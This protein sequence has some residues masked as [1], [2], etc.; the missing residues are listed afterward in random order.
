[1]AQSKRPVIVTAV[2]V[3]YKGQNTESKPGEMSISIT[4][5][6]G[7]PEFGASVVPLPARIRQHA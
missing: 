1:M 6:N 7:A 2:T 4:G 3:I 5:R